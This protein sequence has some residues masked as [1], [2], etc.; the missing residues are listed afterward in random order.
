VAALDT[1]QLD[2]VQIFHTYTLL[3]RSAAQ[4]L[5]PKARAQG[6][7]VFNAGPYAGYILATGAVEGAR[8]NYALAAPQVMDAVRR[9]EALCAQRGITIAQAALAF[10]L[11]SPDIAVTV[12]GSG[13]P[14]RVA[15]WVRELTSPLTDADF[16]DLLAA[17]GDV[18]PLP[19]L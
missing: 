4:S 12:V 14:H 6:T 16:A 1:G 5:F 19:H 3:D 9:M 8:Y 10:S 2:V 13:K 15:A 18:G 11:R 7:P 17:A